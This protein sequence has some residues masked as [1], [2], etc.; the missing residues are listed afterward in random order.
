MDAGWYIQDGLWQVGT[1]EVDLKRF[2]K[3]LRPISDHA[4]AKN[5][6]TLLWFEP[7]RVSSNTWLAINHYDWILGWGTNRRAI[8]PR[9]PGCLEMAG[10]ARR[11]DDY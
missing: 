7:E 8:E 1:W 10:R 3:G 4:H 11:Q 9:Q 2:P 6:K 5:I